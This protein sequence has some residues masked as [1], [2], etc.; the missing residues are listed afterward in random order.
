MTRDVVIQDSES[1]AETTQSQFSAWVMATISS[2]TSFIPTNLSSFPV[3][4]V[5]RQI[6][7]VTIKSETYPCLLTATSFPPGIQK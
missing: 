5:L 6:P 2:I 1:I 4:F 3:L 7:F